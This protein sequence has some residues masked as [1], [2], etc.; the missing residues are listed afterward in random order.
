MRYKYIS[1]DPGETTGVACWDETPAAV[2]LEM[3][4][5]SELYQF[6]QGEVVSNR[7]DEFIIEE[8]RVYRSKAGAHVGSKIPT[9]QVIG[10]LKMF[11]KVNNIKVIEQPATILGIAEKWSG[12]YRPSNHAVGH[13]ICAMLHGY[14]NLHKRGLIKPR[15]LEADKNGS[16]GS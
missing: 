4:N 7:P 15:V 13:S 1:F 9:I 12:V 3:Y 11:A 10:A 5:D 16:P 6:L 14:Y 2:R 8:Y